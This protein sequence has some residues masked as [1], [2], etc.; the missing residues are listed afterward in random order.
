L[1]GLIAFLSTS[2]VVY[3]FVHS[4]VRA[5]ESILYSIVVCKMHLCLLHFLTQAVC[6]AITTVL[7]NYSITSAML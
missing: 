5:M 1:T 7:H 6:L 4:L 2:R 3:H